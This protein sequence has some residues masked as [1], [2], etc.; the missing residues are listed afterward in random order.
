MPTAPRQGPRASAFTLSN[1]GRPPVPSKTTDDGDISDEDGEL[2]VVGS[3]A[4]HSDCA[5]VDTDEESEVDSVIGSDTSSEDSVT[6]LKAKVAKAFLNIASAPVATNKQPATGG[7]SAGHP[8]RNLPPL[9][10]DDYFWV[11]DGTE[12]FVRVR[13]RVKRRRPLQ[14][15]GM[16]TTP[17]SR[18]VTP[19]DYGETRYGPVRSLLLLRA[20]A[21]WRARQG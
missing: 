2:V 7:P 6:D 13:L 12:D 15:G 11:G 10:H 1:V 16:G 18:Q 20:W 4:E 9:W 17:M 14:Y 3:G 8:C 5:V 21:V 19:R